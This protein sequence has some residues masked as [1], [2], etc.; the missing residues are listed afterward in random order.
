[1]YSHVTRCQ[2]WNVKLKYVSVVLFADYGLFLNPNRTFAVIWTVTEKSGI[3]M[4]YRFRCLTQCSMTTT[5]LMENKNRISLKNFFIFLLVFS[6]RLVYVSFHLNHSM[7]EELCENSIYIEFYEL[8][9]ILSWLYVRRI[10][11]NLLHAYGPRKKSGISTKLNQVVC[12]CLFVFLRLLF[13][14]F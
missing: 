7:N 5:M 3:F 14:Y 11:I 4:R 6:E 1:M 9:C 10:L 13:S 12:I 2:E 8:H